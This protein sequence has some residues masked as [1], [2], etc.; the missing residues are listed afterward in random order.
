[1]LS[2]VYAA[3]VVQDTCLCERERVRVTA[4]FEAVTQLSSRLLARVRLNA[5]RLA[6]KTCNK[7]WCIVN[8]TDASIV[9]GC[10][11]NNIPAAEGTNCTSDAHEY[12]V[13]TGV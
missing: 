9:N 8:I 12:G 6:Q 4:R 5:F 11:T 13:S 2:W 10:I 7:L 1:M 3:P